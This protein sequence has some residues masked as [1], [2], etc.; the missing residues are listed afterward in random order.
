MAEAAY[1]YNVGKI[2]DGRFANT[3]AQYLGLR[4]TDN[5]AVHYG[6]MRLSVIA[7]VTKFPSII[8]K[9]SG[10]AYE[11]TPDT[12]IVAGDRG[13]STAQSPQGQQSGLTLGQLSLGAAGR[14]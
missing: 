14:K 6:W 7:D 8:V 12:A 1:S 5:G 13:H 2:L 10:Y 3:T 11:A 4:F 9:V